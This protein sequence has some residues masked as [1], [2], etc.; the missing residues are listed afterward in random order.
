MNKERN[1]RIMQ[2]SANLN[3]QKFERDFN[4]RDTTVLV[5]ELQN[6]VVELDNKQAENRINNTLQQQ[7]TNFI[8]NAVTVLYPEA[9]KSFVESA[10]NTYPF[11][12]Y[13]TIL[14]YEKRYNQNCHLSLSRDN[15]TYTGGAHGTTLRMADTFNLNT[16]QTVPLSSYFERG[17][18]YRQLV[19]Q[20]VLRQ[21]DERNAKNPGLFFEDY[22]DLIVQTFNEES[23]YLTPKGIVIYFGQ[24]DI[25]PYVTGIVEFVIPYSL[26]NYPPSC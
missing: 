8:R 22:R 11:N 13:G 7:A 14:A 12:P 18:N 10:T 19:L 24:Y 16:G 9:V 2:Q 4:F 15:Y 17:S 20:E 26:T 1:A 3:K 6:F 5:L 21:A 23:Y 25:A